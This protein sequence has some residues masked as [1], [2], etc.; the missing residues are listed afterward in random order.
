MPHG[1]VVTVMFSLSIIPGLKAM[2]SLFRI[3]LLILASTSAWAEST[4]LN[5]PGQGW[6]VTFDAPSL[7]KVKEGN[8]ANQYMY[9]GN[10]DRFNL[11]L[12]V[13]APTCSGGDSH[14]DFFKCFWPKASR[15]PIIK[16]ESVK[17]MCGDRYCKIV[18]DAEVNF[19]GAVIQQR[20]MN[21][22]FAY[23]GKWTD[24]HV[25]VVNPTADDLKVLETFE[26]S[27]TYN[28]AR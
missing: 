3:A 14:E 20:S 15:N 19:R 4:A 23:R 8:T 16:K 18:Y 26:D 24:V 17:T 7:T 2:K 5:I 10:A 21:F 28:D 6:K 13:E 22:L 1:V 25:S 27:L 12:F 11:S 9:F